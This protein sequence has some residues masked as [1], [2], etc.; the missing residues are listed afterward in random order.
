MNLV[1]FILLGFGFRVE[2]LAFQGLRF[3]F[4]LYGL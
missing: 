1:Y 2:G 4:R 3:F